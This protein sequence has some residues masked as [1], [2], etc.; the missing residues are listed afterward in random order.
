MSGIPFAFI[1][2]VLLATA[3]S[4]NASQCFPTRTAKLSKCHSN[5]R[6]CEDGYT[7]LYKRR[8]RA[9]GIVRRREREG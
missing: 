9:R 8:R 2:K 6:V 7:F 5:Q 1:N 3:K 4:V